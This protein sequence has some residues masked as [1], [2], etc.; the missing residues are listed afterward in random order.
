MW[1]VIVL[2]YSPIVMF[3]TILYLF[4]LLWLVYI[5]TIRNPIFSASVTNLIKVSIIFILEYPLRS[6]SSANANR[7]FGPSRWNIEVGVSIPAFVIMSSKAILKSCGKS[8][9]PYFS[10]LFISIV[11]KYRLYLSYWNMENVENIFKSK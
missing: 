6:T 7:K 10:P 2:L 8:A 1:S 11:Y 9:S 4:R 5:H 3:C